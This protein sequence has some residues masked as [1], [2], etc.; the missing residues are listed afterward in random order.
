M[1]VL[2][3]SAVLAF[4]TGESG[5]DVVEPHLAGSV[6]GAANF[7]EVLG[8]FPNATEAVF[9]DALLESLGV[10]VE[11]VTVM[12]ARRA[13]RLLEA[14]PS[15]SLGDRLC[16]SLAERL[17]DVVLTADRAWGSSDLIRQIRP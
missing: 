3:A 1:T 13:T 14:N 9:A 6:I 16:L 8:R 17:D 4:L 5:A 7:C 15:L 12:D 2:D 11:P 10:R